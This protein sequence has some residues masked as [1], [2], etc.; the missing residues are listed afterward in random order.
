MDSRKRYRV[1]GEV[2]Y[3]GK[4]LAHGTINFIPQGDDGRG[5]SGTI[6]EGAYDLTTLTPGDGAIPGTYRVTVTA[7]EATEESKKILARTP[8]APASY[9]PSP[10]SAAPRG[11][12]SPRPT[13]SPSVSC[14][15]STATPRCPA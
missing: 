13:R 8:G 2:T 1:Q 10:T 9:R 4:P 15:R 3:N 7:I 11:L 6:Q 14:R 12:R 5:A